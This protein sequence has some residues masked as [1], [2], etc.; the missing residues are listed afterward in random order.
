MIIYHVYKG[1]GVQAV[2]W[3]EYFHGLPCG[4]MRIGKGIDGPVQFNAFECIAGII[5]FYF[6]LYKVAD[7]VACQYAG[8]IKGKP[9]VR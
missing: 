6:A 5:K 7:K 8:F 4:F 1:A 2:M 3:P 9:G